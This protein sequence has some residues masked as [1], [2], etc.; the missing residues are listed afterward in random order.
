MPP[1]IF[2]Q[3]PADELPRS[4]KVRYLISSLAQLLHDRHGQVDHER[5]NLNLCE[6]REFRPLASTSFAY[7][8]RIVFSW[9]RTAEGSYREAPRERH[10]AVHDLADQLQLGDRPVLS[11]IYRRSSQAHVARRRCGV[12]GCL[13]CCVELSLNFEGD[14]LG[15][16]RIG[17][18]R[19][20]PKHDLDRLEHSLTGRTVIYIDSMERNAP[21]SVSAAPITEAFASL[22]PERNA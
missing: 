5:H 8:L 6:P 22:T 10:R 20:A 3:S 12:R 7:R 21:P 18:L 9:F 14:P 15:Y 19:H 16:R 17:D 13:G 11:Q 4:S 2:A 1:I